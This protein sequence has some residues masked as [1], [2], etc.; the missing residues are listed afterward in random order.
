MN[1]AINQEDYDRLHARMK[2]PHEE[3]IAAATQ[4]EEEDSK[5]EED[6]S[7]L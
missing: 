5:E 7:R 3:V 4:E 2:A 1:A 6:S